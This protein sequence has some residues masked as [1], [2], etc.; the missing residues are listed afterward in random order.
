MRGRPETDTGWRQK[1][2]LAEAE[3]RRLEARVL[4]TRDVPIFVSS[5][6][7]LTLRILKREVNAEINQR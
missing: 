4:C 2:K 1:V 5:L 7:D 6:D 3:R